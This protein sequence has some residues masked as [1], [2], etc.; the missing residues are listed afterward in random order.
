MKSDDDNDEAVENFNQTLQ[1][2]TWLSIRKCIANRDFSYSRVIR[3]KI[4]EKKI[5]KYVTHLGI[6]LIKKK[7]LST[8]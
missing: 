7:V 6:Q 3:E 1:K 8:E 4:N 2:V 5:E